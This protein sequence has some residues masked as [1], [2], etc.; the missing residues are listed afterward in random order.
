MSKNWLRQRSHKSAEDEIILTNPLRVGWV[1]TFR[2]NRSFRV[3]NR[4]DFRWFENATI[5]I[6][7]EILS[8]E[9]WYKLCFPEKEVVMV[10][11]TV[12][13]EGMEMTKEWGEV[14]RE[15]EKEI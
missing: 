11:L 12:A 9:I 2:D 6:T 14:A 15:F 5:Y 1:Q 10:S 4:D 3:S 7:E 13:T 8:S